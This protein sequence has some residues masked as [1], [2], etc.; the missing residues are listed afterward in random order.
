M[1]RNKTQVLIT[2]VGG[3]GGMNYIKQ[4]GLEDQQLWNVGESVCHI[5]YN[6]LF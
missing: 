1:V 3:G 2:F 4:Y 5:T 6:P